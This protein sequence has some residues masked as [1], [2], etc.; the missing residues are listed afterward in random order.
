MW[1][2]SVCATKNRKELIPVQEI[3]NEEAEKFKR[4][5]EEFFSGRRVSIE[6]AEKFLVSK[7]QRMTTTIL[8]AYYEELDKA[9]LENKAGRK[10]AGLVVERKGDERRVLTRFGEMG[11]E[12]TYYSLK[13]GGYCY[14]V[15]EIAGVNYHERISTGLATDLVTE[16]RT[17]S[18]AKSSRIV[19]GG[20]VSGQT[21]MNKL[22]QCSLIPYHSEVKRKV[23]FLHVDADEDHVNLQTGKSAIVPLIC[24]YEGIEKQGKRNACK[25]VF[26]I[27]EFRV[28]PEELWEK[29][30]NEIEERYDLSQTVIYLHGDGAAWIKQ[31]LE[32]LPNCK[33]VLDRYHKN[34]ALK[35]AFSG[36]EKEAAKQ[37]EAM[38]RQALKA[39]DR[40]LFDTVRDC[41]AASFPDCA[42]N[43]HSF[44]N[45]L[46]DNFDAITITSTDPEAT[47]GGATEPH[48]SHIL[49]SRLSS[50]PMGWSATTLTKFVPLLTLQPFTLETKAYEASPLVTA[51]QEKVSGLPHRIPNSLG[52]PDPDRTVF[53]A[54]HNGKITQLYRTLRDY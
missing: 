48:V 37:Y 33:F 7:I 17:S 24:V 26:S 10:E 15:D 32:W 51:A 1:F 53:P 36:I 49:S 40:D 31:G 25:N 19:T 46:L 23:P 52:L 43:I 41:A 2:N 13:G 50:R 22:R 44:C 3:I 39:G 6:E 8:S 4:N 20:K 5:M 30:L 35:S 54:V 16:A 45:Y 12:R 21:V 18:Y 29:A 9:I 42:H 27:S 11:F 38:L 14:P 34:Q 47:N 28:K